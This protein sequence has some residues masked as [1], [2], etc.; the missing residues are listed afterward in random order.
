MAPKKPAGIINTYPIQAIESLNIEYPIRD[1]VNA[2][3]APAITA[4][5]NLN[6]NNKI[7]TIA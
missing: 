4:K 1:N 5:R 3:A 6:T 2:I 7:K